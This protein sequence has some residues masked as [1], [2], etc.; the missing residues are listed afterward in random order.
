M[1]EMEVVFPMERSESVLKY[2]N[3][4]CITVCCL[5]YGQLVWLRASGNQV[6]SRNVKASKNGMER[7]N[8]TG[9]EVIFI[10]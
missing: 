7:K 6:F 10:E 9:A 2:V 1:K 4:F 3:N 5:W 8:E